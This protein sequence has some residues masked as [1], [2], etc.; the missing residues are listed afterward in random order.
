MGDFNA[1]EIDWG[2]N[3]VC[4]NN[5]ALNA[6]KLLHIAEYFSLTQHQKEVT[7]TASN[8]VLDLDV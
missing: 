1:P 4:R 2:H 3:D 8:N 6:R 7:R 5:D